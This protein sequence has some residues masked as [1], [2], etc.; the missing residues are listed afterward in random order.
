MAGSVGDGCVRSVRVAAE[1]EAFRRDLVDDGFEIED[2]GVEALGQ[3]VA[4]G[5]A[6]S[7]V[8]EA[9]ELE[10]LSELGGDALRRACPQ[11][12]E[13]A[14]ADDERRAFAAY[15]EGDLA[16]VSG[17]GESDDRSRHVGTWSLASSP[18][19]G[20]RRQHRRGLVRGRRG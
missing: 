4:L 11:R 18:G 2:L 10:R 3:C 9:D 14:I 1:R 20:T 7:T 12:L 5:C 19:R 13:G 8:V 16:G 17:A 6:G 15:G